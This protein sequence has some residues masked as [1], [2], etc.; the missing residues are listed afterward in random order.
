MTVDA[1]SL[2]GSTTQEAISLLRA[3]AA[4][5]ADV[6][7][8]DEEARTGLERIQDELER[9][10]RRTARCRT[11]AGP[12]SLARYSSPE[13]FGRLVDNKLYRAMQRGINAWITT[14]RDVK[15]PDLDGVAVKTLATIIESEIRTSI[16]T[17]LGR[18]VGGNATS[19]IDLPL[20][21]VD[22]KA[23]Q[24]CS[25]QGGL[26]T[27]SSSDLVLGVPYHLALVLYGYDRITQTLHVHGWQFYP[28]W[29]TADHRAS[30]TA[31]KLRRAIHAGKV[32]L[33]A[34]LAELEA[35]HSVTADPA[36]IAALCSEN[37]IP[38]GLLTL[39]KVN[40]TRVNYSKSALGVLKCRG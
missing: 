20:L 11:N 21:G 4:V 27:R 31:E 33:P 29:K 3:L 24:F 1:H 23:S 34:A 40:E 26:T 22:V 10:T 5:D 38:M 25:P 17:E 8:E 37:E 9:L 35:T 39:S 14:N 2:D 16:E 30:H 7:N 36:L 15:R 28:K 32:T 13:D 6:W 19:G 18:E 12:T